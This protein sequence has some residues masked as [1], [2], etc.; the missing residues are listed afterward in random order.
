MSVHQVAAEGF[1]KAAGIYEKARPSYPLEIFEFIRKE[2]P[3][4]SSLF[5]DNDAP[6]ESS[7]LVVDLAAGT[8]KMTRMLY[9]NA[10]FKNIVAV[11]PV[12]EMREVCKKVT[13]ELIVKDHF[14][15][16]IE[17]LEGMAD[18]I[19]LESNSVGVLFVAQAFH[20]FATTSALKEIARV[21]KPNGFLFLVWNSMD[22]TQPGFKEF[23][24]LINVEYYDGVAPQ[25]RTEKWKEAFEQLKLEG[26]VFSAL[27]HKGFQHTEKT[28]KE[29]S[30]DRGFSISYISALPADRKQ[31]LLKKLKDIFDNH[32]AFKD[33]QDKEE[34]DVPYNTDVFWCQ[35]L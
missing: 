17:V 16:R 10:K 2:L 3:L 11:E 24:Q 25:Y 5:Y 35:K 1:G 19:P 34:F 22:P 26:P 32:P 7:G 27:S 28:N 6:K 33:K 13:S 4:S 30:V 12:L 21:L 29:L 31:E 18:K 8:G 15:C 9:S 14:G 23:L 20:W